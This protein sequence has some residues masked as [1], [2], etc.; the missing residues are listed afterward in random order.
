MNTLV[1][2]RDI[3]A[4]GVKASLGQACQGQQVL[5]TSLVGFQGY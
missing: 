1:V 4:I 2:Y 5:Y 3:A